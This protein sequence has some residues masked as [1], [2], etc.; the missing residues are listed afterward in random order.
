MTHNLDNKV[1]A[2]VL[3]TGW[4]LSTGNLLGLLIAVPLALASV[5]KALN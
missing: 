5:Y 2:L 4:S 1:A 3:I